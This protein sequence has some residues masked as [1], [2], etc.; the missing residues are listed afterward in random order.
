MAAPST[1]QN[2]PYFF[3]FFGSIFLTLVEEQLPDTRTLLAYFKLS[4][5]IFISSLTLIE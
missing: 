5:S 4:R 3:L 2:K 1:V